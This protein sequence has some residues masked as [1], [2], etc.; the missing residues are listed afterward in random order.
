MAPSP[1]T[2]ALKCR[3]FARPLWKAELPLLGR[4]AGD[5]SLPRRPA[6]GHDLAERTEVGGAIWAVAALPIDPQ[7]GMPAPCRDCREEPLG[8]Q[9]AVG[10]YDDRPIGGHT[11]LQVLEERNPVGLPGAFGRRPHHLLRRWRHRLVVQTGPTE[12]E[13]VGLGAQGQR[14][15]ASFDER[16]SFR[17]GQSESFFFRKLTCV[18]KR[19]I[20]A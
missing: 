19:P 14:V 11:V 8:I 10:G 16:Y 2:G 5:R 13:E 15:V 1:W 12:A 4:K 20:S 6:L 7:E 17:V 18:V 9:P 3:F